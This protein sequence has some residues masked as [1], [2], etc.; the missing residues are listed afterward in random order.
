[1]KAEMFV[2]CAQIFVAIIA[3]GSIFHRMMQ[4]RV[5]GRL[6]DINKEENE[7]S[8]IITKSLSDRKDKGL[9]N[10]TVL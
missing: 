3:G 6:R 2:L 10:N 9:V 1:V 5:C 4:L 8:Q 7:F